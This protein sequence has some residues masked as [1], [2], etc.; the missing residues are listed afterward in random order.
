MAGLIVASMHQSG[1]TFSY[2]VEIL[3]TDQ[4]K[5][6]SLGAVFDAVIAFLL[7][8]GLGIFVAHGIDS[9]RS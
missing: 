8:L 4:E 7:V 2:E 1:K 5:R 6:P 3:L 9:F